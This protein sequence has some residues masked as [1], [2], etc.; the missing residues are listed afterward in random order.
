[1]AYFY[2]GIKTNITQEILKSREILKNLG[3]KHNTPRVAHLSLYDDYQMKPRIKS[4]GGYQSM[5]Y[6]PGRPN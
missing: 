4:M 3:V 5:Q 1:M 2:D 6:H